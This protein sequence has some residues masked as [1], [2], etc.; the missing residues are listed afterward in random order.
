M[1]WPLQDAGLTQSGAATTASSTPVTVTASATP[2]TKGSWVELVTTT[3]FDAGM[4][5]LQCREFINANG[6]DT[7]MLLDIG[8]GASGSEQV[9][10]SNVLIGHHP[11]SINLPIPVWIPSGSRI[12]VRVQ[13]ATASKAT[14]VACYL[15]GG[16]GWSPSDAG[17]RA[18]TYGANTATSSGTAS[19]TPG[20]ANTKGAWQQVTAS[21]TAPA[22]WLLALAAGPPGVTSMSNCD[23]LVDVGYGGSGSEQALI[24]NLQY[25]HNSSEAAH[26]SPVLVPC[27]I[28][29]GSRLVVRHAGSI[30]SQVPAVVLIGVD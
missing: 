7:S 24:S 2:H 12:A 21:T 13:S 18:T 4:I 17:G 25:R 9:I 19:S 30:T 10:V 20:A 28:P 14:E 8:V 1:Q 26:M 5:W 3:S 29:A 22:R 23:A 11:G 27:N 15:T 16:G 6:V